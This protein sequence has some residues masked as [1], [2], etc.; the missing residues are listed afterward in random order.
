MRCYSP[1]DHR[2]PP[3]ALEHHLSGM[4]QGR[5]FPRVFLAD[6]RKYQRTRMA[7]AYVHEWDYARNG[8]YSDWLGSR[9]FN[10]SGRT[11]CVT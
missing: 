4:F 1:I 2:S 8:L 10:E 6:A 11:Y 5:R 9:V 3:G 7:C